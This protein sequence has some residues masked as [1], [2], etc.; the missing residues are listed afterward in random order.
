MIQEATATDTILQKVL[1]C[2]R[3][4]WPN[5]I[6][7][8]LRPYNNRRDAITEIDGC[9]LLSDRV[10]IPFLLQKNIL[11]QLHTGHPGIVRMKA[12]ARS[13]VY[14]PHIDRKI[15]ETVKQCDRCAK[16]AKEPPKI[17]P[18]PWPAATRPRSRIHI[19][20]GTI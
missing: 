11:K 8:E 15:E 10:I 1:D 6:N 3:N 17:A 2:L 19:D 20:Y 14:W 16:A 13:Y 9:L 4:G 12:L 7:D 18:Q 5:N